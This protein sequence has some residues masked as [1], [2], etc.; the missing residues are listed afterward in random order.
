MKKRPALFAQGGERNRNGQ[1]NH[2][3]AASYDALISSNALHIVHHSRIH[4]TLNL[5]N[6]QAGQLFTVN[7]LIQPTFLYVL[8][9]PDLDNPTITIQ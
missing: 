9:E 2:A 7:L 5:C 8:S 3:P 4:Q 1:G 6:L